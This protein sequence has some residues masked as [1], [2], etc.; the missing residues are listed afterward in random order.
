MNSK[1][2]RINSKAAPKLKVIDDLAISN[3]TLRRH[4][5][6][7][8][9][10]IVQSHHHLKRRKIRSLKH[11]KYIVNLKNETNPENK[12]LNYM[13][14]QKRR[15]LGSVFLSYPTKKT[16]FLRKVLA[17]R[18]LCLLATY[19]E[20]CRFKPKLNQALKKISQ[21]KNLH[22]LMGREVLKSKHMDKIMKI[23]SRRPIYGFQ[24]SNVTFSGVNFHSLELVKLRSLNVQELDPTLLSIILLKAKAFEGL[25]TLNIGTLQIE[26]N[27]DSNL[28][29]NFGLLPQ[30]KTLSLQVRLL[31]QE[32]SNQW[33]Q[34]FTPG[35][36]LTKLNLVLMDITF[37]DPI[38]LTKENQFTFETFT[39]NLGS[40]SNLEEISM[41]FS[42][43]E[44]F[45]GIDRITSHFPAGLDK[46]RKLWLKFSV[47]QGKAAQF[48]DTR[49]VMK[50]I[51]QW[52]LTM[53]QLEE[54]YLEALD[55]DYTGLSQL[56]IPH[57]VNWKII[58]LLVSRETSQDT[59]RHEDL[60]VFFELMK[61][62]HYLECLYLSIESSHFDLEGFKL[63]C[64]SFRSTH[65]LKQLELKLNCRKFSLY[66]YEYLEPCLRG[67]GKL[68]LLR[69]LFIAD[70]VNE[71]EIWK[72]KLCKTFENYQKLRVFSL[73]L[74][75]ISR[76]VFARNY[77]LNSPNSKKG[78]NLQRT[79]NSY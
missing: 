9:L 3:N 64:E 12:T 65:N 19:V 29:R 30:L 62:A 52:M 18:E 74:Y 61:R 42:V 11:V 28:S 23:Y 53:P 32:N 50:N 1:V 44:N 68:E 70:P 14:S 36:S 26:G 58:D 49:V 8:S 75:A 16:Y 39:R 20:I 38:T 10:G 2:P 40:A 7:G 78:S 60:R 21:L 47:P 27:Y 17:I 4:K 33:L 69:L 6:I 79:R 15:Y 76:E 46:M 5:Y 45:R 55:R 22:F 41:A 71:T 56:Q 66:D 67:L 37:P 59:F 77:L 13:L 34:N 25:E 35:R 57:H 73:S 43:V 54:F 24:V 31:H 72:Y 48:E 51:F 63:L